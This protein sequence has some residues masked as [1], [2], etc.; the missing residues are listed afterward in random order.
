MIMGSSEI[1]AVLLVNHNLRVGVESSITRSQ[2]PFVTVELTTR[3]LCVPGFTGDV[4]IDDCMG[5]MCSGNRHCVDGHSPVTVTLHGFT[6]RL[7]STDI[8]DCVR[9]NCSGNGECVDGDNTFTCDCSD[10]YSGVYTL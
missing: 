10:G 8:D 2:V 1:V 9:V 4:N 6:G 7:C 5:E 3:V